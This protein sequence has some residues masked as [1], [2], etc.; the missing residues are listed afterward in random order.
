MKFSEIQLPSNKKFGI[1]FS[2]IFLIISIYSFYK[3]NLTFT[4]LALSISIIFLL[5]SF[6]M[7]KI[8]F[9]INK[10]WMYFGYLLGLIISPIVLGF[11]FFII[12][13]PVGIL[14]RNVFKDEL[15]L[16]SNLKK[17][18]WLNKNQVKYDNEWF[19]NQF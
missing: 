14:R 10:G 16:K 13:T 5:L 6:L 9:P 4:I 12:F 7:P 8:L 19:R 15:L 17:S 3:I 11:I 1:T 2:I 18:Y